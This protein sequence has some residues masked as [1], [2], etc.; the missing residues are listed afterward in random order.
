MGVAC[1]WLTGNRCGEFRG[2]NNGRLTQ[3]Q[4]AVDLAAHCARYFLITFFLAIPRQSEV[5]PLGQRQLRTIRARRCHV[6]AA[7][8]EKGWGSSWGMRRAM[9]R[10]PLLGPAPHA[11][12]PGAWGS[13]ISSPAQA[14]CRTVPL[15]RG[16]LRRW[17]ARFIH[18][19][20]VRAR[21][22]SLMS[23][24]YPLCNLRPS[25]LD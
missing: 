4:I 2:V 23:L 10:Q 13:L 21:P 7:R 17:V 6:S 16:G 12:I 15:S 18:I 20:H 3:V 24:R 11:S 5:I 14:P 8:V 19:C 9:P 25:L 1:K 22:S